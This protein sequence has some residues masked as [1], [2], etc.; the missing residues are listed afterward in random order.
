MINH[1]AIKLYLVDDYATFWISYCK[2]I[3]LVRCTVQGGLSRKHWKWFKQSQQVLCCQLINN[4]HC[5]DC[6]FSHKHYR[7]HYDHNHC[8]YVLDNHHYWGHHLYDI[9]IIIIFP[10]M[11]LLPNHLPNG[12]TDE[13][14]GGFYKPSATD[15]SWR[16]A[17]S[18][19]H[20]L[21]LTTTCILQQTCVCRLPVY[22]N[23]SFLTN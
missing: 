12:W 6:A 18:E 23:R 16:E 20:H 19:D 5:D 7:Y 13:R 9:I 1:N 10:R 17:A 21:Y 15:S 4:Q 2:Y 3:S 14:G 8:R 11:Y 22:F